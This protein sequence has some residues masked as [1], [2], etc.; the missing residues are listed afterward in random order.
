MRRTAHVD[1]LSSGGAWQIKRKKKAS[2]QRLAKGE[3]QEV[4]GRVVGARLHL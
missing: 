1:A 4:A 3:R 2:E